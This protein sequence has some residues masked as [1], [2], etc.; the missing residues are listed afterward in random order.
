M[1]ADYL[2]RMKNQEFLLWLNGLK[3]QHSVCEGVRSISCLAPWAKD[4]A[5]PRGEVWVAYVAQIH[6]H[7]SGGVG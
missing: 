4:L 5:L 1:E 3:T 7:C 2:V 6:C